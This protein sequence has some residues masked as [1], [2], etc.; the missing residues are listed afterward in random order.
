[1]T[2]ILRRRTADPDNDVVTVAAGNGAYRRYPCPG[3]PWRVDQ[4]GTFPAEAFAHAAGTAYD[5]S[6]TT[7]GCH[8]AGVDNPVTCAGFLLRGAGHN[9]GVRLRA[10]RGDIDLSAVHTN[11]ARLHA[12]YRTMATANGVAPTDE[13]LQ[14]CRWSPHEVAAR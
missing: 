1:M 9:L 8:E 12:G 11:G 10:A 6:T 13:R 4:T 7:F 3:C 2:A 14:P 5:M